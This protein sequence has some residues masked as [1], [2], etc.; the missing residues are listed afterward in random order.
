[1]NLDCLFFNK[2]FITKHNGGRNN[3]SFNGREYHTV[4]RGNS[5]DYHRQTAVVNND[6]LLQNYTSTTVEIDVALLFID[7]HYS[8]NSTLYEITFDDGIPYISYDDLPYSSYFNQDEKEILFPPNC[9]ISLVG[10]FRI[11]NT[12]S[13]RPYKHQQ[14]HLSWNIDIPVLQEK[15]KSVIDVFT[16]IKCIGTDYTTALTTLQTQLPQFQFNIFPP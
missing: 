15:N 3:V 12:P 5:F 4:Y 14:V 7:L 10:P 1:M 13:G 9:I 16:E 8:P 11:V 6:F 2:G